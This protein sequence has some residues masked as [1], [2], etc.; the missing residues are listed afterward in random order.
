MPVDHLPPMRG[1]GDPIGPADERRPR[2]VIVGAGF[3]GLACAH[4]LRSAPVEI[5]VVDQHNYHVF[6]PFLYQLATALLEPSE[7][8]YPVRALLR[9]VPN[10]QFRLAEVTD[11]DLETRVVHTDRGP[12]D[13]HYLVLAAGAVNNYFGNR[14]IA[15]RSLGL[16]DLPEALELRN[17]VLARFERAAWATDAQE[18]KRLLSFAVVGGGPTGTEFAAAL[19]ELVHGAQRRDY[20][21][22]D[23]SEVEVTLV[24]ASDGP[25]PPYSPRLQRAAQ[26]ALERKG[27]RILSDATAS[28]IEREGLGLKDG[29]TIPAATV[30]WAAGV[31]AAPLGDELGLEQG[32]HH[33][34]K[35]SPSLQVP[36]HPE[37][38][39]IGDLAEVPDGDGS[40][41]MLAQVALQSGKQ[42][43]RS[44]A[45][46]LRGD[47]PGALR[48]HDLGSMATQGRNQAVAQIGPVKLSGFVGWLAWLVVHIVR[49][50]GLRTRASVLA[51]WISGYLF[52]DRPIRLIAVPRTPDPTPDHDSDRPAAAPG[53]EGSPD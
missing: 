51:N 38:F 16:N 44:I 31:R 12:L 29:R 8:A 32:S 25:L 37:V 50:E 47:Q 6:T 34:L 52:R 14:D 23:V 40:L 26:R 15:E 39:A 4:A 48:Y 42:A 13:Y 33:R 41:P 49:S 22:L 3:G 11:V 53:G 1:D 36:G 35:V 19:A 43:G 21:H 5:V 10:A 7:T 30:V 9:R 2:V 24:E 46:L 27:V 18:R 17:T 45:A 28:K 20:P